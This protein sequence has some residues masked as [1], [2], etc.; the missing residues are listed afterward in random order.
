M[1]KAKKKPQRREWLVAM[2]EYEGL[3]LL[4]RVRPEIDTKQNKATYPRRVRVTH[5]LAKVDQTGLPEPEYNESLF[6]LDQA[7]VEA[8]QAAGSGI[9]VLIETF[10]GERTYDAYIT[11][12]AK[13]AAAIRA[14]KKRFPKQKITLVEKDDPEWRLYNHYH[15]LFPWD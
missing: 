2:A 12:K 10:N 3:P 7:I 8:L 5:K 15:E 13:P 6:E 1:A 9:V 4:L 14:L 11:P